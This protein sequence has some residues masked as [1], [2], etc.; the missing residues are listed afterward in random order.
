MPQSSGWDGRG[1]YPSGALSSV[2]AQ[3]NHFGGRRVSTGTDGSRKF[4]EVFPLDRHADLSIERLQGLG[5]RVTNAIRSAGIRTVED[6]ASWTRQALSDVGAMPSDGP[7]RLMTALERLTGV[8]ASTDSEVKL[9]VPPWEAEDGPGLDLT[10]PGE[11]ARPGSQADA[12]DDTASLIKLAAAWWFARGRARTLGDIFATGMDD[13]GMPDEVAD[14]IAALREVDISDLAPRAVERLDPLFPLLD[15]LD[16][17]EE[18]SHRTL[19]VRLPHHPDPPTLEAL[20]EEFGLTRERVRQ[21]EKKA[22]DTLRGRAQDDPRLGDLVAAAADSVGPGVP[23]SG[24]VDAVAHIAPSLRHREDANDLAVLL[25]SIS[26]AYTRHGNWLFNE[27]GANWLR[28]T[29]THQEEEEFVTR[30]FFEADASAVGFAPE[31][32]TDLRTELGLE[33]LKDALIPRSAGIVQRARVV[34]THAGHPLGPDEIFERLGV[35]RS[36]VSVRNALTGSDRIARVDRALFGLPGWGRDEYSSILDAIT[37]ELERHGRP[38]S[39]AELSDSIAERFSVS[40]GSVKIYA[41]SDAFARTPDGLI[42]L[43]YPDEE[44]QDEEHRALETFPGCRLR[45]SRWSHC[46]SVDEKMLRGFSPSV[47]HAFA[48]HLGAEPMQTIALDTDEGHEISVVRSATSAN[49][50][51]LRAICVE[52]G[53]TPGDVLFVTA[54]SGGG[55]PVT[56]HHVRDEEIDA[57]RGTLSEVSL[58]LGQAADAGLPALA[59]ALALPEDSSVAAVATRLRNRGEDRLAD[60]VARSAEDAGDDGPDAIDDVARLLGL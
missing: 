29:R 1:R 2:P 31:H 18:R 42:R 6:L 39:V 15:A 3:R 5:V 43:R 25:L 55:G 54:A 20:G 34:L 11:P 23:L 17:V 53:L 21:L 46:F 27:T 8:D 37:T 33:V 36:P 38:M 48:A 56:V 14:A 60:I 58:L 45:G 50:G 41:M 59:E 7:L 51:R 10:L 35:D 49:V 16:A 52:R 57:V 13:G 12:G 28:E 47:P 32:M 24:A 19:I 44:I 9:P 22:L 30:E 26:G 4:G 40:R